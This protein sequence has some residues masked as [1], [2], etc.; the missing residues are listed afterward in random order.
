M[1][2]SLPVRRF[3]G[4]YGLTLVELIVAMIVISVG[5]AGVLSAYNISVRASVDP[6]LAK[7]AVA[8]G[9]ALLEEVRLAP[10]TFCDPDD[11]NAETAASPAAC[12]SLPEGIG[13]EAGDARPFD[14]VNDYHG[15]VLN[16][17][18]DV[19]GTAVAGLNG[20]A[21]SISVQPAALNSI[22]DVSGEALR[23]VVSVTAPT[24][25]V[26]AIEGYRARYAPNALP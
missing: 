20:F 5:V 18:A 4:Q 14:N 24:G 3:H 10:S 13:P 22:S 8:I 26:F 12:A 1:S 25:D 21:A 2:V 15:L 19:S 16:P 7:Q 9:E 11:A 17:I 6:M 23:I